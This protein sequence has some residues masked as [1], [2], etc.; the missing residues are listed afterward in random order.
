MLQA[1]V[2]LWMTVQ[3]LSPEGLCAMQIQVGCTLL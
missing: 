2:R 3:M 1:V